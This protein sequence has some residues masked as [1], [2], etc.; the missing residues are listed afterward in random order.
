MSRTRVEKYELDFD[1]EEMLREL[2]ENGEL[3][4]LDDGTVATDSMENRYGVS[5]EELAGY[6][7]IDGDV[8]ELDVVDAKYNKF[9]IQLKKNI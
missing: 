7:L 1:D 8:K 3:E 9:V 5:D 2:E 4:R 6:L